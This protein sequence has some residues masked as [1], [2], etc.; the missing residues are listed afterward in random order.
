MFR[1]WCTVSGGVTGYNEGWLKVD[2]E[3]FETEWRMNAD[4]IAEENLAVREN[5]PTCRF[6]YEVKEV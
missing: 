3:V 5:H 1:V 4:G 6:T 2:G